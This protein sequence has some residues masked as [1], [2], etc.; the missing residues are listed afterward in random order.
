MDH[1]AGCSGVSPPHKQQAAD[2]WQGQPPQ[3]TGPRAFVPLCR[4]NFTTARRSYP[5]ERIQLQ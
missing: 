3:D 1:R 5:F 4:L 2:L